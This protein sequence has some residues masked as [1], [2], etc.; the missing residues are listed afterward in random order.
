[1]SGI[2]VTDKFSGKFLPETLMSLPDADF[3][4]IAYSLFEETETI[5]IK[6]LREIL[7]FA[8]DTEFGREHRFADINSVE[9]FR[10]QVS[11]SSWAEYEPYSDRL[12]AGEA[13]LLFPGKAVFFTLTSGTSGKEKFI[14]D[15]SQSA[16]VRNLIQRYRM[17]YYFKAV[18]ELLKGKLLPLTNVPVMSS[19][20]SGIP[21]GTASGLTIGQAGLDDKLAY[22]IQILRN[23][24]PLGRDYLLMRLAIEQ[25]EVYVIAGNNAGR[26]TGLIQLAEEY[27]DLILQDIEQGT[28]AESIPVD[29]ALRKWL[30][31]WLIPNPERT[32]QLRDMMLKGKAFVPELYW[33]NLKLALFWLSS[34]VGHYV[35][36][37]RSLLPETVRFMDVG[38][39]SSE[40]KFNIPMQP[41]DKSGALS[42][43]TAFYEFLPEE[44]GEPLLAHQLEVGKYYELIV[45]TWGGL[46]R[47]NMKD[48]V[49][50]TGFVGN[51]PKIEFIRKSSE[52]LNVAGEKLPASDVNDCVRLYL[53]QKGYG[54][55]QIQ[56]YCDL[57]ERRYVCYVETS[58]K[59][60]EVTEQ[61]EYDINA[62][63]AE[64]F[65]FYG[66]RIYQQ[67]IMKPMIL[68]SMKS[69][70]QDF[71][72]SQKL[73]PGV[74]LSQIK[75]PILIQEPV[76][77][78]WFD[79]NNSRHETATRNTCDRR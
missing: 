61:M 44:G 75:L 31:G 34:S 77:A 28:I 26:L 17:L 55:R 7:S 67:R 57:E 60:L 47:Y 1:M 33:P 79:V 49:L 41:E 13:D 20:A 40:A 72:Y 43:A 10:H 54:V 78:H 37:V 65:Q 27:K 38:Y 73:K 29:P 70:W 63:L 30:D 46:Y 8:K 5:Q 52:L 69:G 14:P 16:T 9:E 18:P 21:Y 6:L 45:T 22:P 74:S 12:V 62:S 48:I 15:S 59:A 39:G 4:K 24:N 50:V 23:S 71:L 68:V 25:S 42:I 64:K 19:T 2:S 56:I 58:D 35:D 36:E 66:M 53:K 32:A 76:D 51:T 11:I 3:L